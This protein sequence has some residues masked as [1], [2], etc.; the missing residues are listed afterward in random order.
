MP[1]KVGLIAGNRLLPLLFCNIYKRKFPHNQI[2]ACAVKGDT[3]W[4]INKLADKVVWLNIEEFY[5]LPSIFKEEGVKE[6]LMLGQITP[7]RLFREKNVLQ[8]IYK[9]LPSIQD[10]RTDTIFKA[11]VSFLEKEGI[12]VLDSRSFLEEILCPEGVFSKNVVSQKQREDIDFGV[13][14]L[15]VLTELDISQTI[16]VKNKTVLSI[17]GFEGTDATLKRVGKITR[18]SPGG[19]VIKIAGPTQDLR[20]DVPVVGVR[21]LMMMK[22]VRLDC[23]CLEAEKTFILEKE[24]FVKIANKFEISLIGIAFN[25]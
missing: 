20:F 10:L 21:T 25:R 23:L 2:I 15:K 6:I 22:K 11:L 24:K 1:S 17:E 16:V 3:S 18:F 13:K 9:F 12:R 5:K 7:F 4:K 8:N 19:V 14:I